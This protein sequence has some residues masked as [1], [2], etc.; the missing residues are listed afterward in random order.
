MIA[1]AMIGLI[2]RVENA[3]VR[4]DGAVVGAVSRG[5]LAFIAVR[6]DDTESEAERLDIFPALRFG[7]KL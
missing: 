3:A 4:V 6:R 5:L 7:A 2:Q 1:P